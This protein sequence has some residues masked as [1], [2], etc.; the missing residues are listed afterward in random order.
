MSNVR[1]L[2]EYQCWEQDPSDIIY[3]TFYKACL[4]LIY[5]RITFTFDKPR[6]RVV[7]CSRLG[8]FHCSNSIF[9]R[10]VSFFFFPAGTTQ[11]IDN[12]P[13]HTR[14]CGTQSRIVWNNL[15]TLRASRKAFRRLY[16]V[17]PGAYVLQISTNISSSLYALNSVLDQHN[18]TT[19]DESFS[20]Q[21][22]MFCTVQTVHP[23]NYILKHQLIDPKMDSF[24][25]PFIEFLFIAQIN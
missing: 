5:P 16:F 3:T 2:L 13:T 6:T 20:N 8:S 15:Y 22:L 10:S 21:S 9:S 7:S 4:S 17:H 1:F 24:T 14:P 19:P 12:R 23:G 18:V 25:Y 11:R